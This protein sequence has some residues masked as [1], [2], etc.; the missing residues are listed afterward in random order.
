MTIEEAITQLKDL[1]KDRE[2]FLAN[3]EP[4]SEFAKDIAAIDVAVKALEENAEL[5]RLLR[6]AVDDF[7]TLS[8]EVVREDCDFNLFCKSC[9]FSSNDDYINCEKNGNTPKRL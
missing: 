9:P 3:D 6:L 2:T 4:D 8:D 1:R 7:E 5:K